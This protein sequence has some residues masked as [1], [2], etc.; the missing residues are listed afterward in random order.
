MLVLR[1]D[2]IHVPRKNDE[3]AFSVTEKERFIADGGNCCAPYRLIVA[4][5]FDELVGLPCFPLII[6]DQTKA[7]HQIRDGDQVSN[8]CHINRRSRGSVRGQFLQS[9]RPSIIHLQLVDHNLKMISMIRAKQQHST[10]S[11]DECRNYA[12]IHHSESPTGTQDLQL[13]DLG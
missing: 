12:V 8:D 4:T 5:D 2:T 13:R 11:L 7:F 10:Y 6:P 9:N 1:S 3:V